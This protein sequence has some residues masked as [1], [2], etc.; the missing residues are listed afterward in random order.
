MITELSGNQM[1]NKWL[2]LYQDL[3]YQ[4]I[5]DLYVAPGILVDCSQFFENGFARAFNCSLWKS[6]IRRLLG[7]VQGWSAWLLINRI[8]IEDLTRSYL[9]FQ[10]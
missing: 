7:F 10:E 2:A 1:F 3:T 9:N 4:C 5:R 6:A 8:Q